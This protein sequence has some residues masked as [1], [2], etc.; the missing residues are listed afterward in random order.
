MMKRTA[1]G[2][3]PRRGFTLI[4][5]MIAIVMLTVGILGLAS[6]SAVI[7]KQMG[8]SSSQTVAAQIAQSRFDGFA[9]VDCTTLAPTATQRDSATTRFV[10]EVWRIQDGNDI[11]TVFDTITFKGRNRPLAYTSIIPCRD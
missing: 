1:G 7:V 6:T 9:S 11:K 2:P 3:A 4:E 8:L 10:K 5:L